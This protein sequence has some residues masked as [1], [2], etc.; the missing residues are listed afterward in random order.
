MTKYREI[1]RLKSLG[2]SQQSI[3]D[4]CNVSKKTVNRV[5]KRAKELNI[6]W[7]LDKSDTDAVLAEMFF[8]SAKQVRS[9]KRMPDYDYIHKELLRNG[10]SKKLLWTE[11]MEDCHANGEEPLMYSQFCIS[12]GNLVSRLRSTG[13]D[14]LLITNLMRREKL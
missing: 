8:P 14:I 2:L 4:S 7:P 11:Y 12:T 10:V 6:S 13:Y 5:L 1:L 3:A 9:N